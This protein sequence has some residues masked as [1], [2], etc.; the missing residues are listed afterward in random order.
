[1]KLRLS[2]LRFHYI[3]S[4]PDLLLWILRE[5][6][7]FRLK[8]RAFSTT[9]FK[10]SRRRSIQVSFLWYRCIYLRIYYVWLLFSS[11]FNWRIVSRRSFEDGRNITFDHFLLF[12]IWTWTYLHFFLYFRIVKSNIFIPI[13][14][15]TKLI[16]FNLILPWTCTIGW[17]KRRKSR[18]TIFNDPKMPQIDIWIH[19]IIDMIITCM[20]LSDSLIILSRSWVLLRLCLLCESLSFWCHWI[21]TLLKRR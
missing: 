14:M 6:L 7:A 18:S 11:D 4:R 13:R 8:N 5:S 21:F 19:S 16:I 3:R 20:F 1:M 12:V 15:R 17:N 10:Q 9:F 2:W